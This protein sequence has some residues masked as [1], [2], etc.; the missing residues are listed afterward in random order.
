MQTQPY[1]K[2]KHKLKQRLCWTHLLKATRLGMDGHDDTLPLARRASHQLQ[3][4]HTTA[5]ATRVIIVGSRSG[6]S[7]IIDPS[8][9]ERQER[10]RMRAERGSRGGDHGGKGAAF[11]DL[12]PKRPGVCAWRIAVALASET[13][14]V[15]GKPVEIYNVAQLDG[16]ASERGARASAVGGT[17]RASARGARASAAGARYDG[18]LF[19]RNLINVFFKLAV[20]TASISPSPRARRAPSTSPSQESSSRL[21]RALLLGP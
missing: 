12:Q 8:H 19:A 18:M 2:H 14:N 7:A 15:K 6:C 3:M 10:A 1:H 13:V 17:S 5:T 11:S 16:T 21:R 20:E 4:K 9:A